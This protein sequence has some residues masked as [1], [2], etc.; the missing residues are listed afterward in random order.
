MLRYMKE[1]IKMKAAVYYSPEDIRLEEIPKPRIGKD[2]VLVQMKACGI[3]GS[4]LMDW[5][6]KSRAPLILGHEPT[7]KIVEVGN[8]VRQFRVDD[9]VFVHHH[10]ACLTC[11]LCIR[12]DYTLCEEFHKTNI[13]PGGLAE[14]FRVPAPNL[15]I[16][17][18]KIPDNLTFEETTMIEP[19]G[20]CIRALNK[21]KIQT[22][23]TVAIIGAG[24]T[25]IVHAILSKIFGAAK[26]IVSDLVEYRL[27]MAKR[28]RAD[29]VV[30][31]EKESLEE[32]VKSETDGLGADLVVVTAP[33]IQ[34]YKAGL[35]ICRKGGKV[36]V[37]APT[38]PG[39]YMRIS[40]KR[41]FFSEIQIIPSYSTSHLETRT[42][43]ELLKNGR[44]RATEL[45]TH[46]YALEEVAKAYET[47]LENKE[48]LKVM[49]LNR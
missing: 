24:T 34:A 23:D 42:A 38:A 6:L 49:V 22:G 48:S 40:P 41:L 17:T 33:D 27:Q 28:A 31:P 11:H 15:R 46:R 43:L 30:N 20:C 36:C 8:E 16:D 26:T 4:D 21:C 2:E 14:F 9:R 25:G 29:V 39:K 35:S 37:F 5:Y 47:A 45:I 18:L 10:V 3:C 13:A 1:S 44:I 12:G 32:I 7:G 19:I